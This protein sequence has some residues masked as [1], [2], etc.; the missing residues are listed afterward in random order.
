[1]ADHRG[2]SVMKPSVRG[3][4]ALLLCG[5]AACAETKTAPPE[6]SRIQ[7]T[8]EALRQRD[9][10]LERVL[11][12]YD[13]LVRVAQPLLI[14]SVALCGADRIADLGIAVWNLDLLP[15]PWRGT[16][17]RE[18]GVR[19]GVVIA[20]V[21]PNSNGERAGFKRRDR[22]VQLGGIP[23]GPGAG[24]GLGFA[25]RVRDEIRLGRPLTV[26]VERAGVTHDLTLT[27]ETRCD[28]GLVL[29]PGGEG[30]LVLDGRNIIIDRTLL[31]TVGDDHR[32]AVL[33]AHAIAHHAMDHPSGRSS[34][35]VAGLSAGPFLDLAAG[36]FAAHPFGEPQ[37]AGRGVRGRSYYEAL[38]REA[39]YVGLYVMALAGYPLGNAEALWRDLIQKPAALDAL[40][41][42]HP[43]DPERLVGIDLA[44]QEIAGKIAAEQALVPRG[45]ENQAV[46][47]L[48][49]PRDFDRALAGV[50]QLRDAEE[51]DQWAGGGPAD[52]CGAPWEIEMT[53]DD[54]VASGAVRRDQVLYDL[55]GRTS[56]DGRRIEGRAG[57]N[58]A[59]RSTKGPRLLAFEFDVTV[60][61]LS[62]Y[63][64][65]EGAGG[66]RCQTPLRLAK[67]Q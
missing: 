16:V 9:A 59:Y 58:A 22:I 42:R 3:L 1:M 67:M 11:E 26:T 21:V 32:L 63:L 61:G 4:A 23:F 62:G 43:P 40:A 17:I 64:A 13:R 41:D 38:E 29:R 33:L 46:G 50:E 56:D 54:G 52:A 28:I 47:A 37:R 45:L 34:N 66:L 8:A 12:D 5:L 49:V 51:P 44:R 60:A 15:E 30:R 2:G 39:D 14:G 36:A 25:K 31:A 65:I 20:N 19:P 18:Q 53:V 7:S 57:R 24:R 10:S 48:A 6:V 35:D 27:P 55:Q